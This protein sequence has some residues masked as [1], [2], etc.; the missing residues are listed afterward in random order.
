MVDPEAVDQPGVV[1][2]QQQRVAGVEHVRL[3]DPDGD[4][5]IDLEESPVVEYV[6][7]FGVRRELPVLGRQQL[8]QVGGVGSVRTQRQHM[9]VVADHGLAGRGAFVGRPVS[10]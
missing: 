4:Q 1:Q 8:D 3:L 2:F 9:L 6:A 5:L 10:S 7:G